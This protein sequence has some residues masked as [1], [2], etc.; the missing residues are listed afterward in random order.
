MMLENKAIGEEN[1]PPGRLLGADPVTN[2]EHGRAQQTD[3]ND[4]SL[5]II[6]LNAVTHSDSRLANN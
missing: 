2:F 1:H 5:D 6:D 4:V 3:V